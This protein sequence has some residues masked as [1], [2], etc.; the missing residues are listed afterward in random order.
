MLKRHAL[1]HVHEKGWWKKMTGLFPLKGARARFFRAFNGIIAV[2]RREFG[3]SSR[4]NTNVETT[5]A[6]QPKKNRMLKRH[7][8]LF[9]NHQPVPPKFGPASAG[10][11]MV[12]DL[13]GLYL[14]K[15]RW[16]A[17][18]RGLFDPN[19]LGVH[20]HDTTTPRLAPRL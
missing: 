17:G 8:G 3:G 11:A 9:G 13:T 10:T 16:T 4:E 5:W 14:L 18:W 15:K 1:F 2:G 19:I 7:G 6:L 12:L 20:V